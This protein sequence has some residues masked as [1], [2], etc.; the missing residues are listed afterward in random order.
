MSARPL[1]SGAQARAPH[2]HGRGSHPRQAHPRAALAVLSLTVLIINLDGTI[3]NVALPKIVLSL[4]ATASQVQWIVDAYAVVLA[5]LLLIAGSLGD[6]LGRKWVYLAGLGVFAA[7]SALSALSGSTGSLVGARALMGVGAAAIMPSSLSILTNVFTDATQRARAIGLWSGTN[8]LGLA[9]GPTVGGWLLAHYWWGSVFLINVPI[10]VVTVIAAFLL[11]P[12]SRNEHA[13]SP[14]LVGAIASLAGVGLLLWAIIEGPG[15]GWSSGIIL[16]ALI[17]SLVLVAG[18]VLWERRSSHALLELSFF[19]RARFS[20]A[21]GAMSL[22][23]F[24][25]SGAM[26]LLTQYLQFVLGY[27]ALQTGL[28]ITPIAVVLI[29]VAA[30]SSYLVTYIGTKPVVFTGLAL[31]ALG[32]GRL[33]ELG[34]H[35]TYSTALSSFFLLGIGTGLAVAPATESVMGS[36]PLE[37]AGVG[38]ATNSTFLQIGG[39]LGV[40][41]LGSVLSTHYRAVMGATV[42][43]LGLSGALGTTA[44][45]SL[46]GALGVAA[47]VPASVGAP[48]AQA[49]RA[50]FVSAMDLSFDVGAFIVAMAAL[51]VIVSLPSRADTPESA[52]FSDLGGP[53]S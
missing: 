44:A 6:H 16:S 53:M 42:T 45:G 12:D 41:V 4:H 14:D 11:I 10:V 49:G 17:G 43:H 48:L 5:G 2:Q 3:L 51:F 29:A 8:G 18:F 52:L 13:A 27:S 9:I 46:G 30:A 37:L 50:A 38:S 23:I 47:G 1:Q 15:R 35:S 20:V 25:L 31:I 34:M 39:A 40:G 33:S 36:V 28:R 19:R 32:L 21:I 22:T 7:G 26:F 24:A